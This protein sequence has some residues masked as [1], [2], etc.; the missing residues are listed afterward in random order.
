[1][2]R[3]AI[4]NDK[5]WSSLTDEQKKWVQAAADE[6]SRNEPKVAFELEH[7][8]L[9]KLQ[10]IGVKVVKDVDKSGFMQISKP[11][12]DKLRPGSWPECREGARDGARSA[13][14]ARSRRLPG[15]HAAP[16]TL[17]S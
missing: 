11:I 8:A 7:Q 12:Q 4:G 6:V 1:L 10:K 16:R 5:A 2:L 13:I 14:S 9:A 15:S 3:S 17:S